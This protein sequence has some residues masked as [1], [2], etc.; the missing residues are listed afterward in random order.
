MEKLKRK[1]KQVLYERAVNERE[2]EFLPDCV[3]MSNDSR[4]DA[5]FLRDL[6]QSGGDPRV[7]T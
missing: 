2:R 7:L 5:G 1:E 4:E 6:P 3:C